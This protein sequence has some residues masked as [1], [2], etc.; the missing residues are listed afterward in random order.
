MKRIVFAFALSNE[1][2]FINNIF[3]DADKFAI[4]QFSDGELIFI[5]EFQNPVPNPGNIDIKEKR[6]RIVSFL[7]S[8]DVTVLVSKQFSKN[9]RLVTDDFI[10]VLIEKENPEQVVEILNKNMKWIKDELKNRKSGHMLFRI[11]TGVLKLAIK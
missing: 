4:Y 2:I 1:N 5:D 10:P 3:G 7:K 11:N 8:K 6:E 9:L